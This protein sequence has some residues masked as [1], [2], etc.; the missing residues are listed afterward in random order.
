MIYFIGAGPGDKELITVKGMRILGLADCIIYAGSLINPELLCYAKN[1][2]G[3]YNSA[4]MTLEE[5]MEIMLE[6]ERS[7]LVTA[8]LHTGDPSLY[9]AIKEQIDILARNNIAYEI[10]PGVSSFT[11]AAAVKELTPGM[12][13]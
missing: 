3:F 12:I 8:R 10:I 4:E 5:V 11:A 9:G 7:K 2:C 1:S 6:N 13:S